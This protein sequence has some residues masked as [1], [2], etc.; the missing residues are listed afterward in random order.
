MTSLSEL[1]GLLVRECEE[2]GSLPVPVVVLMEAEELDPWLSSLA[3][4]K[5]RNCVRGP[6]T[7]SY[8]WLFKKGKRRGNGVCG[9]TWLP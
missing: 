5:A 4:D 7:R 8:I 3:A 9:L 1:L 2:S 6:E